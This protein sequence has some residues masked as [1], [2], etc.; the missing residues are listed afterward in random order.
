MRRGLAEFRSNALKVNA[1]EATTVTNEAKSREQ[2]VERQDKDGI[3]TQDRKDA[4]PNDTFNN[5]GINARKHDDLHTD[6]AQQ[7]LLLDDS[8]AIQGESKDIEMSAAPTTDR[9]DVGGSAVDSQ[10][11]SGAESTVAKQEDSGNGNLE[12]GPQV[13]DNQTEPQAKDGNDEGNE[14]LSNM[15]VSSLLPGLEMYANDPSSANLND[16]NSFTGLDTSNDGGDMNAD[17]MMNDAGQDGGNSFDDLFDL[18][19]F[20]GEGGENGEFATNAAGFDT[21]FD[22]NFFNL[23]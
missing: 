7:G 6:G 16:I 21:Q 8:A 4:S 1:D 20:G 13:Q 15:D 11:D 10:G 22:E 9:D 19:E 5:E 17:H 18:G 14:A 12:E 2:S 23:D 3:E